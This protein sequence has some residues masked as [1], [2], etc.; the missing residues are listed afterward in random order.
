[1]RR[2]R[3]TQSF[4]IPPMMGEEHAHAPSSFCALSKVSCSSPFEESD[5]VIKK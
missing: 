3:L 1:M 5:S 2:A 4:Y